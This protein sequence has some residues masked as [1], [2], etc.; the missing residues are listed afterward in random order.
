MLC[1]CTKEEPYAKQIANI[2][3]DGRRSTAAAYRQLSKLDRVF[4]DSRTIDV[5][6]DEEEPAEKEAFNEPDDDDTL[7]W[8][9]SVNYLNGESQEMRGYDELPLRINEL[10]L[11]LLALFEEEAGMDDFEDNDEFDSDDR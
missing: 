5:L 3:A 2:Y 8:E 11:E 10:V 4:R 1:F 6:W 9:V 7:S